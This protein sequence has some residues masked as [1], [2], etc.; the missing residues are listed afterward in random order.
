MSSQRKGNALVVL[1]CMACLLL[2]CGTLSAF[3]L[4]THRR[5]AC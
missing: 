5:S 4:I 2:W 1:V 3:W